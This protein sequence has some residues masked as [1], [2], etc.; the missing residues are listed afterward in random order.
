MSSR[1]RKPTALPDLYES[2]GRKVSG[3][4]RDFLEAPNEERT[5]DLRVAIRK[6]EMLAQHVPKRERSK[7]AR[8]YKK[9]CERFLRLTSDVRDTDII[10]EKLSE[11][12]GNTSVPSLLRDLELERRRLVGE[13]VRIARKLR[14]SKIP[15]LVLKR[16]GQM[17]RSME[18]SLADFGE[19]IPRQLSIVA[20]DESRV[21]E[22]HR[23][24]KEARRFRYLLEMMPQNKRTVRACNSLRR[25]QDRL[26]E[27]RDSDVALRYLE[28]VE[29]SPG[30]L[31]LADGEREFRNFCYRRLVGAYSSGRRDP[32]QSFLA[33]AGLARS[34]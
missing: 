6:W 3:A 16:E 4:V 25:L 14:D 9:R 34:R 18:N 19:E 15:R 11:H 30:V 10:R 2:L 8:R 1:G 28:G 26:G 31:K 13:S 12:R 23:L 27:I 21:K 5:H 20:N 33:M 32:G 7:Q 29:A 17:W 24:K 22:L